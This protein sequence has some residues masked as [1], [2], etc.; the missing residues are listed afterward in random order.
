MRVVGQGAEEAGH[1]IQAASEFLSFSFCGDRPLDGVVSNREFSLDP[2]AVQSGF[3]A[4]PFAQPAEAVRNPS[5]NFQ[6]YRVRIL[7]ATLGAKTGEIF[8][9]LGGPPL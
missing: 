4:D 3:G 7:E 5:L 1:S 6:G 8:L 9:E 2:R